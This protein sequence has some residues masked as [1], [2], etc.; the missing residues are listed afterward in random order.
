MR[1][2]EIK[3]YYKAST[4]WRLNRVSFCS[5]NK[6]YSKTKF[7]T[8][9]KINY[10]KSDSTATYMLHGFV[11]QCQIK[12]FHIL[13]SGFLKLWL[14]INV[15]DWEAEQI[16]LKLCLRSHPTKVN[17]EITKFSAHNVHFWIIVTPSTCSRFSISLFFCW[18]IL[19]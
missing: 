1:Y 7:E 12:Y 16:H 11:N 14:T 3:S 8:S 17:A 15:E 18:S 4:K 6:W 10:C 2:I 5:K 13:Y 19:L 9:L